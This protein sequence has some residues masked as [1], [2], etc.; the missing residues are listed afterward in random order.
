MAKWRVTV[1]YWEWEGEADDEGDALM[2]AD[3]DFGF[4]SEASAEEISDDEEEG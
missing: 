1:N 4:M 3:Y 2:Q